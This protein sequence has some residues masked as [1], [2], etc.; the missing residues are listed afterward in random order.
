VAAGVRWSLQNG[1][2]AYAFVVAFTQQSNYKGISLTPQWHLYI[3]FVV[4][5]ETIVWFRLEVASGSLLT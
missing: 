3:T 5:M 1:L 2:Y 4:Y